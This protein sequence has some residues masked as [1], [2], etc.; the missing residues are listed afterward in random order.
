MEHPRSSEGIS[1]TGRI[2]DPASAGCKSWDDHD[3]AEVYYGNQCRKCG[4]FFTFG[5]AP[6]DD[7]DDD[8]CTCDIDG[9]DNCAVHYP[10][11][12]GEDECEDENL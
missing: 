2:L 8:E 1:E 12:D 4:L 5:C 10:I 3:F 11:D 6:W 9:E 7:D